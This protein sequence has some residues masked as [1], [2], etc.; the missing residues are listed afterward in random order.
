MVEIGDVTAQLI[1]GAGNMDE[2]KQARYMSALDIIY[3]PHKGCNEP[4]DANDVAP[5]PAEASQADGLVQCPRCRNSLCRSCKVVWHDKFTCAQFQALPA[6]ERAPEDLVFMELAKKEKWRRCPK[7]SAMVELKFGCNHITCN[8]K[9][10][11][12]YT[13]GADFEHKNGKYSCTS[14]NGCK[15]WDEDALLERR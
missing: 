3:C 1:L 11:F 10:H 5:A 15:V 4:F 14:G 2:W 13:C 7:C 12:C 9:H 6:H 8:C